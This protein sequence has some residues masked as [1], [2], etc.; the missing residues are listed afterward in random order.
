MNVVLRG[1]TVRNGLATDEGTAGLA[2]AAPNAFGGGILNAGSLTLDHVNVEGNSATAG[3]GLD[4]ASPGN[5]GSVGRSGRGG[6][7]L[8]FGSSP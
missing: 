5:A 1:L 6:G 2:Q 4:G 8:N 7:I 3:A